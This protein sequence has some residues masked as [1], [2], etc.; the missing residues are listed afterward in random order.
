MVKRTYKTKCLVNKTNPWAKKIIQK[1]KKTSSKIKYNKNLLEVNKNSFYKIKTKKKVENLIIH[2]CKYFVVVKLPIQGVISTKKEL[3]SYLNRIRL[4]NPSING[5][6]HILRI[7]GSKKKLQKKTIYS[8]VKS[9]PDR[10]YS[11]SLIGKGLTPDFIYNKLQKNNK[12]TVSS[13]KTLT[14]EVKGFL[15]FKDV[16]KICL[17]P[18]DTKTINKYLEYKNKYIEA[19]K[20]LKE[21]DKTKEIVEGLKKEIEIVDFID[22]I[23]KLYNN[24]KYGKYKKNKKIVYKGKIEKGLSLKV[25]FI[26]GELGFYSTQRNKK[27]ETGSISDRMKDIINNDI[28]SVEY[29]FTGSV[30]SKEKLDFNTII[31]NIINQIPDDLCINSVSPENIRNSGDVEYLA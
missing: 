10:E 18:T 20:N 7:Q 23:D 21:L 17:T 12:L 14:L 25:Y 27:R 19:K 11:F 16:S 4:K 29:T 5:Y 6:N 22:K 30:A 3:D 28:L 15:T 26:D 31:G 1:Y 9:E 8:R 13:I 2:Q 24:N